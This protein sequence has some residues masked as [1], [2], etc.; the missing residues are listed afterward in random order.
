MLD[1]LATKLPTPEQL[2]Q[3]IEDFHTNGFLVIPNVLP[4]EQCELL[5]HDLDTALK[6]VEGENYS[7]SKKIMKR[8]FE[9]SQPNLDLF[10][11]EP[12][13]T[14]AEHL[15]GGANGPG[16]AMTEGIPNANTIHV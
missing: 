3:W 1:Y 7:H 15:I 14:F 16:Y 9:R 8:M 11:L 6:Q 10:A 4:P 5:R 12:I 13:V 2:S